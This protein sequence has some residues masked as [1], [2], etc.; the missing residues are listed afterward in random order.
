MRPLRR[1]LH[2]VGRLDV[3]RGGFHRRQHRRRELDTPADG[4]Q[5]L[6]ER[7]NAQ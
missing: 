6:T 4:R 1:A 5:L 2:D 7:S 3:K